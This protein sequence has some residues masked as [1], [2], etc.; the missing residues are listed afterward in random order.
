MADTPVKGKGRVS[1]P[2]RKFLP[3]INNDEA[4]LKA[5]QGKNEGVKIK[6]QIN[7]DNAKEEIDNNGLMNK[8]G[9]E[10]FT[11]EKKPNCVDHTNIKKKNN[12]VGR[13]NNKGGLTL[14]DESSKDN[15]DKTNSITQDNLGK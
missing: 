7:S 10:A 5:N 2:N 11:P 8:E 4:I 13:K 12:D 3:D 6:E 9:D 1:A 15:D 14:N